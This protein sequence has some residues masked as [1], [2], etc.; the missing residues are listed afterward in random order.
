MDVV[1]G[2]DIMRKEDK[3][4]IMNK[5]EKFFEKF[6]L[7]LCFFI[8]VI[9]CITTINIL[10]KDKQFLL[11]ELSKKNKELNNE[12]Y[13]SAGLEGIII[14]QHI[15]LKGYRAST[16]FFVEMTAYTARKE[17]TNL[18]YTNTAI[19]EEPIAGWTIAVSQDLSFLLG[20]RVYIP[21]YGIRKVN[22]LMNKRYENRIDILVSTTTEARRIGLQ[23][24]IELVLI[25]PFEVF[26]TIMGEN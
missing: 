7:F 15:L 21:E 22:D 9:S 23:K 8:I 17:E 11:E 19:M 25:E 5:I 20:K 10:Y 2:V 4:I 13:Y 18:D 16:S 6:I 3:K 12:K 24:D 14:G 1:L 26:K